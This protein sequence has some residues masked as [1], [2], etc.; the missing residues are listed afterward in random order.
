M[1]D[2]RTFD[3]GSGEG[4][5]KLVRDALGENVRPVDPGQVPA[6]TASDDDAAPVGAADLPTMTGETIPFSW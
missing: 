5:Q 4:I 3:F 1:A 6:S 2:V